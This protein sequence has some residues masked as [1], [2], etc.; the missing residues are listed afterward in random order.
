MSSTNREAHAG[1]R[2]ERRGYARLSI[3]ARLALL[4]TLSA[5]AMLAVVTV[6][7]YR[8]LIRGLEWDETQ[9]VLDKIMMFEATL[10]QHGDDPLFLDHEVNLEGGAY[11]PDQ[12]YIMYSRILDEAGSV[13]IETPGMARLIPPTVFPSP[14]Q[15]T[16]ALKGKT[17]H[18][19]QAPN[20]RAYFLHSAMA[21]SG[22]AD[23]PRRVIQVAMDETGERTQIAGYRRDTLLMLAL[24]TLI[25]GIAGTA[26]VRRCLRPVA[27][28]AQTAERITANEVSTRIDSDVTR[29]PG[30]LTALAD[31]FYRML[32]RL[33][34]SYTRCAQC[35][36]DMAHELRNPIHTL[37][38]EAEVALTRDRTPDE[39]RQVL[40]SSLEE[41]ARL[42]RLIDG[43]LFIAR[44]DNPD[45]VIDHARLE[46]HNELEAVRE[47]HDAQA[48]E[49]GITI[50]CTGRASL[51][52]EPLLLRRAI[53]N[54]VSN[55]LSHTPRGG[56]IR[57]EARQ[58][59]HGRVEIT[60]SDTGCGIKAEDLPRIF[61]RFYRNKR[62]RL[63]PG[64]NAG[65]G[66][67]IVRSIMMLHGGTVSVESAEG[68]GTR[69]VLEFPSYR[70]RTEDA[71]LPIT[72][73]APAEP[74]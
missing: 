5:F 60:V 50:S 14:A 8:M 7:Q 3:G 12:H 24:G 65:L 71:R 32:Y 58:A 1:V 51:D 11:W 68:K 42:S 64:E 10:R 2:S 22:G 4:F 44:A 34:S 40:E 67:A 31:A 33:D 17:V 6:I 48:L 69:I 27:D 46:V 63:Q 49:Q 36:E 25:F 20:G 16:Q 62:N 35:A 41:Y 26:I 61:D 73:I 54:L 15:T 70:A 57:L 43:L 29:W 23:G 47:F 45:T 18:Y 38:G 66:L 30:E 28:L 56:R 59:D 9:L 39:Y 13:I 74:A 52:A 19:R 55:A 37:M 21:W 53:S 72:G